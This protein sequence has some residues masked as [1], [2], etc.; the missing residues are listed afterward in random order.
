[1]KSTG[2]YFQRRDY[3]S[4]YNC[5]NACRSPRIRQLVCIDDYSMIL[6]CLPCLACLLTFN[7]SVRPAVLQGHS[8]QPPPQ[9]QA[10]AMVTFASA[11]STRTQ[12][13]IF[14]IP[15]DS[16]TWS[17]RLTSQLCNMGRYDVRRDR[18]VCNNTEYPIRCGPPRA[19]ACRAL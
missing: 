9:G 13:Y 15:Y 3:M 6:K 10:V 19:G 7:T 8:P 16:I 4:L 12:G 2:Y 1:M 18:A 17:S 5:D 14:Q 11:L